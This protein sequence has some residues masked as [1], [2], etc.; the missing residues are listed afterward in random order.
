MTKVHVLKLL[1]LDKVMSG[2]AM[3]HDYIVK[4]HVYAFLPD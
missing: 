2:K 4:V 3:I 1:Y